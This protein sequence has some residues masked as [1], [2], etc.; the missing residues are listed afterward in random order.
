MLT[1]AIRKDT[2]IFVVRLDSASKDAL[3]S[4]LGWALPVEETNLVLLNLEK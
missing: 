4:I 3:V 2:C 1:S